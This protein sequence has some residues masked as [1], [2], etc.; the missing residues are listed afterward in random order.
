MLFE[1]VLYFDCWY[2]ISFKTK[3]AFDTKNLFYWF[4][5]SKLKMFLSVQSNHR[6]Q[7]CTVY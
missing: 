7:D 6:C 2:F 5:I 4:M 3:Q 1:V